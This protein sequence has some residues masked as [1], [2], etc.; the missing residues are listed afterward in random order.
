[1]IAYK[2]KSS[3]LSIVILFTSYG[4]KKEVTD[5]TLVNK[6]TRYAVTFMI[7]WNA[8]DYPVDYPG[9]AHFSR[10]IGWSHASTSS[11]FQLGT[12]ASNGIKDMAELGKTTPL[13]EEINERIT[14][15]EGLALVI[16]DQLSGTGVG[17]ITVEIEVDE[18][19]PS[20][21]LATMLAPSPDWFLAVVNVNLMENGQFKESTTVNG[22]VYDAGT[23]NGSTYASAN[24]PTSPAEPIAL[25][26]NSPLGNANTTQPIAQVVFTKIN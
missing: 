9:N 7:D 4:C 23:D 11:F 5:G 6:R 16:G 3:I 26:E 24:N 18:T 19:R 13:D 25:L 20:V 1:M 17:T 15:R 8:T 12:L 22:L 2:I 21:T 14:D 10:L